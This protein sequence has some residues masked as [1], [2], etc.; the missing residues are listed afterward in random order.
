MGDSN[1][2]FANIKY[3]SGICDVRYFAY[4]FTSPEEKSRFLPGKF[5]M[6]RFLFS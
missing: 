3:S 2:W 4:H 5:T 6:S 1:F